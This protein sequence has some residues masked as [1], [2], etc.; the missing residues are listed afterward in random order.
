MQRLIPERNENNITTRIGLAKEIQTNSWKYPFGQ[1]KE[2]NRRAI[3]R[4]IQKQY[5]HNR[6]RN[7]HTN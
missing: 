2:T 6:R 3:P 1:T 5:N 7:K 4:P